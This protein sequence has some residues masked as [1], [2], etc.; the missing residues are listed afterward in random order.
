MNTFPAAHVLAGCR[1]ALRFIRVRV[2]TC[3]RAQ[4]TVAAAGVRSMNHP[5]ELVWVRKWDEAESPSLVAPE[6]CLG[7][8]AQAGWSLFKNHE[9]KVACLRATR[10]GVHFP[11][12]ACEVQPTWLISGSPEEKIIASGGV[13]SRHAAWAEQPVVLR[14]PPGQLPLRN[15]VNPQ[16]RS[17]TYSRSSDR[18]ACNSIYEYENKPRSSQRHAGCGSC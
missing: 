9:T 17:N 16:R 7:S 10:A 15:S 13:E 14:L 18:P 2:A 6:H 12:R 8:K 1:S 4:S 5:T 3:N 11:L